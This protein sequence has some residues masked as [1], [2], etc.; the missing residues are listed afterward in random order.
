MCVHTVN[1][2]VYLQCEAIYVCENCSAFIEK[3]S[4]KTIL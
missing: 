3:R 2:I 4:S 1:K